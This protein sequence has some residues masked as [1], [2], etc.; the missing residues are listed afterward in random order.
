M[1]TDL[2]SI[3][4]LAEATHFSLFFG[5]KISLEGALHGNGCEHVLQ[6]TWQP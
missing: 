5:L 4:K 3:L 2:F 1:K 6:G